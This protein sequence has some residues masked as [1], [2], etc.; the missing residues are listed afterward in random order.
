MPRN[1]LLAVGMIAV[2]M[3]LAGEAAM[4]AEF[5]GTRNKSGLA[6]GVAFLY[7]YIWFYGIFLD[8]PGYYYV[9]E[10]L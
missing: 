4:T 10:H 7:I 3:P 8:G 9:R 6:A 1:V 2:S 5:V